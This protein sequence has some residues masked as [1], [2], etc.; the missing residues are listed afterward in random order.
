MIGRRGL[1]VIFPVL[2]PIFLAISGAAVKGW[3]A[4]FDDAFITYRC[5]SFRSRCV[6]APVPLPVPGGIVGG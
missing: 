4:I 6:F 3:H 5:H 1:V 2:I